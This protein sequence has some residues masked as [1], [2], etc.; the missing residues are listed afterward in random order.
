MPERPLK[1]EKFRNQIA[2][3][4]G[5]PSHSAIS[6]NT[7]GCGPNSASSSIA[8]VVSHSCASLSYSASSRTK[9]RTSEASPGRAGRIDRDITG[10]PSHRHLGLDVRV[11]CVVFQLEILEAERE[12]VFYL[13]I[14]LHHRQLA[15]CARQ[16]QMSL[17]QMIEIEMRIAESVD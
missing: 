15:W 11:R 6:Q 4:T 14:E 17:L 13:R 8:A 10:N 1:V 16:L 12:Q 9:A 2:L 5:S 3:P 7:R